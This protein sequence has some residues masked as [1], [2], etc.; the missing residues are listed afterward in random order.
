VCAAEMHR[1]YG[2]SDDFTRVAREH[3]PHLLKSAGAKI[4]NDA[5]SKSSQLMTSR[6]ASST[7]ATP[8][9]EPLPN[10][11]AFPAPPPPVHSGLLRAR[12]FIPGALTRVFTSCFELTFDAVFCILACCSLWI[13]LLGFGTKLS[14][15]DCGKGRVPSP[16]DSVMWGVPVTLALNLWVCLRLYSC[17]FVLNHPCSTTERHIAHHWSHASTH[18]LPDHF[19]L[20]ARMGGPRASFVSQLLPALLHRDCVLIPSVAQVVMCV[21]NHHS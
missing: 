18:N 6:P 21:I 17:C 20:H 11:V 3:A 7:D 10:R 8:A 1:I 2:R 5:S 14:C 15:V 4:A 19:L 16:P 13:A 12:F 9:P